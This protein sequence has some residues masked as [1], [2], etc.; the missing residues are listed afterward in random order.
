MVADYARPIDALLG[1]SE[2][3]GA[4]R[5]SDLGATLLITTVAHCPAYST[6]LVAT[7][8]DVTLVV[9]VGDRLE[10]ATVEGIQRGRVI[11]VRNTGD[12]E[13]LRLGHRHA[14]SGASGAGPP[15]PAGKIDWSDG[16]TRIDD[17]RTEVSRDAIERAMANLDALAHGARVTPD[18]KD[19]Q[20]RGYR[21][22]R[23]RNGSAVQHLQLQN[24]DVITQVN[25]M[26][27]DPSTLLGSIDDLLMESTIELEVV[28]DGSPLLL[29][30]TILP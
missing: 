6:A 16:I 9:A 1:A 28:R 29:D 21:V 26:P 17:T 14:R 8:P 18:F 30:Y 3:G 20:L 4:L 7:D 12:R 5:D 24:N 2:A 15:Q 11:L 10:D 22:F 13:V 23:I 19:G 25:G 27:V